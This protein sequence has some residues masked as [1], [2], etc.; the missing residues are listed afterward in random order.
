MIFDYLHAAAFQGS[1]LGRTILGPVENIKKIS[2][3]DLV[4]YIKKYYQ[5]HKMVVAGAGKQLSFLKAISKL[6]HFSQNS[7]GAVTHESML[8]LTNKYFGH[9]PTFPDKNRL[10]DIPDVITPEPATRYIGSQV[11]VQNDDEPFVHYAVAL[12]GVSWRHPDYFTMLLIQSLI[13]NY[14][15][16]AGGNQKEPSFSLSFLLPFFHL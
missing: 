3:N 15:K 16:N 4:N 12:E 11:L 5:G 1:G 6:T 2:R 9:F 8:A 14:D 10:P 7:S 13:G